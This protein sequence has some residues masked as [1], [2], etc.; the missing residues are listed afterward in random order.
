MMKPNRELHYV[1]NIYPFTY[2]MF[3]ASNYGCCDQMCDGFQLKNIVL[4]IMIFQCGLSFDQLIIFI[5]QL[6]F[7]V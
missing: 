5:D 3:L 1:V 7:L 6:I 4:Y 2:L